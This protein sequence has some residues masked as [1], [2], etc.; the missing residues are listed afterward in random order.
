[1]EMEGIFSPFDLVSVKYCFPIS[2]QT[3][4][5]T[6]QSLLKI[7]KKREKKNYLER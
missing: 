4:I 2:H 1:M 7:K 5:I 3:L 6:K